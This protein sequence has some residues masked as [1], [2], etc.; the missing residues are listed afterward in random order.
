MNENTAKYLLQNYVNS[1]IAKHK[2]FIIPID[3]IVIVQNLNYEGKVTEV[4][5]WRYL[6]RIAYNLDPE[7]KEKNIFG[8]ATKDELYGIINFNHELKKQKETSKISLENCISFC[9]EN[10]SVR[11]ATQKIMQYIEDQY[12]KPKN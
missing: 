10:N 12:G 11:K 8:E 9:I 7:P 4:W 6:L 5:T 2:V 3:D 1:Q